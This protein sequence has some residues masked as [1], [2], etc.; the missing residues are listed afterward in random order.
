MRTVLS[1]NEVKVIQPLYFIQVLNRPSLQKTLMSSK[2]QEVDIINN[3]SN[4]ASISSSH[5]T[6]LDIVLTFLTYLFVNSKKTILN[7]KY[8]F[9]SGGI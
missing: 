4:L 9:L 8:I 1:N 6:S 5:V 3:I 7:I 2:L